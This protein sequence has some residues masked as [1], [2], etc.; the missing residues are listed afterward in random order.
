MTR[1]ETTERLLSVYKRSYN[2]YPEQEMPGLTARCEYFE[3][4]EKYV[5]SRKAQLWAANREEFLYLI[6]VDHLTADLYKELM[7]RVMADG[8]DRL[9]IGPGHMS[10]YITAVIV[11]DTR[12]AEAA[13]ALKKSRAHK[14][15]QF[16][17]QGW[18]D[19]RAVLICT[20]NGEIV[21]N[22]AARQE[23]KYLKKV[24]Y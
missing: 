13:A 1:N 18:M 21:T 3:E 4:N 19:Y 7:D 14:S 10:S 9:H 5:I 24:L 15:F 23:A 17:L 2:I 12:D 16:S 8:M 20:E 22:A 11:C 6:S